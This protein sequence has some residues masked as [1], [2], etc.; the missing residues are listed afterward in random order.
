MSDALASRPKLEH[1]AQLKGAA[2]ENQ[3]E[4]MFL[5][6]LAKVKTILIVTLL[7][8]LSIPLG[9]TSFAITQK[10]KSPSNAAAGPLLTRTTTRREVSRFSYGGTVTLV[11]APQGSITIEGWQRNEVE[12]TADIQL[13]AESEE[14]LAR[15]ASVNGFI[16]DDTPNHLSVL[17]TGM[18]DRSF[19]RRIKDFPKR[20]LT[21]PWKIDYRMRVPASTDLEVSG[22]RGRISIS[23]VEGT[24]GITSP[25]SDANLTFTGGL[26]SATIAF[27]SVT[28]H[29]P[30]RSWRGAGADVKLAAGDLTV[31]L[32]AGFNGDIDAEILRRGKIENNY[33][34]L[35]PRE[36]RGWTEKVIRGRAGVSGATFRFTVGDGT[37]HIKKVSE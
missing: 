24:I 4:P 10:S 3:S 8:L 14:D 19:M 22:G 21:L 16:F 11:G 18:H 2:K 13:Q 37:I 23:G 29:V 27:G 28:L 15:L 30:V 34:G 36:R 12:V 33:A 17:T 7:V 31:E 9:S 1:D 32:P 5:R 26:V 25:Q 6:Q 20:L 35:E